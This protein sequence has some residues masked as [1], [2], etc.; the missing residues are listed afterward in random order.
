MRNPLPP[1]GVI[2]LLRPLS[3]SALAWRTWT[4]VLF[5]QYIGTHLGAQGKTN[6]GHTL[7]ITISLLVVTLHSYTYQ[8]S[9]IVNNP[10]PTSKG[11]SNSGDG[12]ALEEMRASMDELRL[13]N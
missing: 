7:F 3:F 13:H 9:S 8:P 4:P 10:T 12:D 6:P 1:K 11:T 5:D 2:H